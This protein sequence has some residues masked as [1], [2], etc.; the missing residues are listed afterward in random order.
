MLVTGGMPGIRRMLVTGGMQGDRRMR[1]LG[2]M[3]GGRRI[4]GIR[5]TDRTLGRAL[6]ILALVMIDSVVIDAIGVVYVTR[7]EADGFR[8]GIVCARAARARVGDGG[9]SM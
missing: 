9:S 5:Q 2:G 3:L 6:C 7:T 1:V 8:K 4:L